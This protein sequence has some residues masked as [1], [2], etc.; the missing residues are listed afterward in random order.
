[1]GCGASTGKDAKNTPI[2]FKDTGVKSIDNLFGK[3]KELVDEL[4][5]FE[6]SLQD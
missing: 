3:A 2:E 6:G 5:T 4:T 1:M